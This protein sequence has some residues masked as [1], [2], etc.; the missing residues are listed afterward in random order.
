[1]K[2]I[3]VVLII[4]LVLGGV[5]FFFG[6][7]QFAVPPN[8]VAV[9]FTKTHGWETSPVE[10]GTFVWR[11]QRL[12]PTNM[13]LYIFDL[14][15]YRTV[16]Q[17]SGSLP[18]ADL[19]AE[20]LDADP[21]FSYRIDVEIA[22]A[23]RPESVPALARDEGVTPETLEAWYEGVADA[24]ERRAV[25]A[26]VATLDNQQTN[27]DPLRFFAL[28][29]TLIAGLEQSF[30]GLAF[31]SVLPRRVEVPDL[32]LY[33][34][35]REV[36]FEMVDARSRA[37]AE[38]TYVTTREDLE[39]EYVLNTLREYAEILSANPALLDY[40]RLSADTGTDPLNLEALRSE[41]GIAEP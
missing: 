38:A 21:D 4:L 16:A 27:D 35:A 12:I 39:N 10:P 30:S 14:T 1:M 41:T 3:I 25:E 37:I 29:E 36:Y 28:E 20:Y 2:R 22:F 34:R 17:A 19:Y 26:I 13:R 33:R 11:W 23:P 40:F 5:V 32:E 7:V 31:T 18:S 15:P 8:S 6:W 24:V 9:I